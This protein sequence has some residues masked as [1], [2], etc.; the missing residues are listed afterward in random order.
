[1]TLAGNYSEQFDQLYL[2]VAMTLHK[3]S[4]SSVA[5]GSSNLLVQTQM[6]KETLGKHIKSI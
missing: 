1:M 3:A 2:S 4:A 5:D 6:L